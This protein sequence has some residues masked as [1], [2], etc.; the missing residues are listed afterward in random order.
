MALHFRDRSAGLAYIGCEASEAIVKL[1]TRCA[2]GADAREA[3]PCEGPARDY[4]ATTQTRSPPSQR[5]YRVRG[6]VSCQ[7]P[8]H[9][10]ELGGMRALCTSTRTASS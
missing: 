7:E 9:R 2:R 4:A 3:A 5:C 1:T 8:C 10:Q 6:Y